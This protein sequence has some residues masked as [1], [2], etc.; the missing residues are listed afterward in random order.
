MAIDPLSKDVLT[1]SQAARRLPCLRQDRPISPTTLWRWATTGL[2]GVVLETAWLGGVLVTTPEA[3]RA[4]FAAVG[5]RR[6]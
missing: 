3:L 5:E 1:L 4:F 6:Q 2:G